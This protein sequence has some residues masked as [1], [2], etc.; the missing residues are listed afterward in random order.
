MASHDEVLHGAR[1][2]FLAMS[3]RA[4]AAPEFDASED[5]QAVRLTVSRV[6]GASEPAIDVEFLGS[7]SLPIG[8]M[9][10]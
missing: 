5:L 6:H 4:F 9:S 7:H 2:A 1:M 3:A 8:G 10:L